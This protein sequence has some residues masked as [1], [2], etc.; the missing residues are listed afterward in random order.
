MRCA[1][2]ILAAALLAVA[3]CSGSGDDGD[4]VDGGPRDMGVQADGGVR[5]VCPM[6]ASPECTTQAEC[7]EVLP[8]QSNCEGCFDYSRSVCSFGACDSPP[9]LGV[10][11]THT[12]WFTVN[13]AIEP[14]LRSF[15]TAA[16]TAETTGGAS[17]T[18]EQVY[19]G[20]VDIAGGCHNVIDSRGQEIAGV[21]GTYPMPFS[22][23]PAERRVLFI[24]WGYEM[25]N[26]EGD[27]LGV[28]CTE[29]EV[30]SPMQGEMRVEGDMMRPIQ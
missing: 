27:P 13:A 4:A 16:L 5:A 1:K 12:V 17:V 18:C 21:A 8:R 25:D 6:L 28:S 30:G 19:A 10:T 29:Y 14:R 22:R 24:I 3:G 11:D 7:G 2:G 23:F 9:T 26:S 20:E 15:A